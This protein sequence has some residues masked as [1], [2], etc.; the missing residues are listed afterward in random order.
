MAAF[1]TLEARVVCSA[2]GAHVIDVRL[3]YRYAATQQYHYVIGDRISWGI[4]DV[5]EPTAQRVLVAG[6]PDA[7]CPSC[8]GALEADHAILIVGDVLVG[9]GGLWDPRWLAEGEQFV[10]ID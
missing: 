7:D 8:G 6:L 10:A 2:T 1:N 4:N 3:Q 9:V 5:G